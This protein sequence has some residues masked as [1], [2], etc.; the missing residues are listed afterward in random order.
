MEST[1]KIPFYAKAALISIG[2]FAFVITMQIGQH[3]IIPI[4]YAT[5]IAIL[6]N[7][8]VNFLIKKRISK[9]ISITIAVALFIGVA[10]L[11]LY[12]LSTQISMF[13][14]TWPQLKEKFN[15]TSTELTRW[16]SHKFNIRISKI[17]AWSKETQSD[18]INDFAIADTLTEATRLMISGMLV[19][20][21]LFM[22]LFYKPL[23]LEFIHKLFKPAHHAAVTEVLSSTKKITQSY[24][25]GLFFEMIIMATLQSSVLLLIG[26]DYAIIL[27]ITGAIVNIIPYIGGIVSILLPMVIAY[28]TKD[29]LTYPMLVFMFYVIIQFIDNHYIIPKI[30]ASRVQIN[31]LV[32]VIVVLIGGA[33]WGIPGMFLSIPLTAILKVIFDHIEPLKPWGFLL[34]NIVPTSSTFSFIKKNKQVGVPPEKDNGRMLKD[35]FTNIH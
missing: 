12:I 14:E 23:L 31:A 29:T 24:L 26:I 33:L 19:P 22:I 16:V 10:L 9:L 27:G 34:G 30:V 4:I 25:V 18:A 35:T 8:F 21:Y 13:S 17:N 11:V 6:L 1:F 5:L 3:I 2:I 15:A 20:V 32:S 28:V 7:P